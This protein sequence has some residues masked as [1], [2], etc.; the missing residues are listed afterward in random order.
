MNE[1]NDKSMNEL[2]DVSFPNECTSSVIQ[3]TISV[4][5]HDDPSANSTISPVQ[6]D[7]SPPPPPPPSSSSLHHLNQH[8]GVSLADSGEKP[9][10]P[11]TQGS[12]VGSTSI[13]PHLATETVS[14]FTPQ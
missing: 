5:A 10:T 4:A 2:K 1:S 12:P 8:E 9:P 3:T 13:S 14:S 7:D 6:A 11:G